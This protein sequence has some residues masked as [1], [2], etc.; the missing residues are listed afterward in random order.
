M[1]GGQI[2]NSYKYAF[3]KLKDNELSIEIRKKENNEYELIVEDNGA[4]LDK[5]IDIKKSKSLGLRLVHRLVKQ[6]HG[7]LV[8]TN[9]Q[10]ARFEISFKDV[11][12]RKQVF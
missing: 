10:G 1:G 9:D 7:S 5:D 12:L 8:Q 2:T 3:S 6:L 4:G 11:Y